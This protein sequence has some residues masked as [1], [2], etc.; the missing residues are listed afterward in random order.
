M[1]NAT[2]KSGL[3][4]NTKYVKKISSIKQKERFVNDDNYYGEKV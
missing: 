1:Q 3:D 4:H 2:W